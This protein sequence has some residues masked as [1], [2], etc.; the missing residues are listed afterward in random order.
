MIQLVGDLVDREAAYLTSDGVYLSVESVDGYGLL[1]HQ[2]LDDLREAR[3][4][5]PDDAQGPSRPP[6]LGNPSS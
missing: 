6:L 1:A 2:S 4:P 3:R 5:P